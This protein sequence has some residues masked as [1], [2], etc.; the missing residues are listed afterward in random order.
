[1][2]PLALWQFCRQSRT[3]WTGGVGFCQVSKGGA[4]NV[5]SV[6]NFSELLHVFR[7]F[8]IFCSTSF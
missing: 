8:Y 3:L 1:M 4:V 7:T 2:G 6:S 5:K